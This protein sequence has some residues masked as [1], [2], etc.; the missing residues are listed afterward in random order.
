[1]IADRANDV[2]GPDDV[3]LD[4]LERVVLADRDLLHRRRVE[5]DVGVRGAATTT[6]LGVADVADLEVQPLWRS[7]S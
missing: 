4:R 5:D 7:S 6:E 2:L 1:M 3:R